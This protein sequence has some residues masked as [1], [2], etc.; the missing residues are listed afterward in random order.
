M[1]IGA[2]PTIPCCDVP[3]SFSPCADSPR[4]SRSIRSLSSGCKAGTT[5]AETREVFALKGD[6]SMNG[7]LGSTAATG[8]PSEGVDSMDDESMAGDSMVAEADPEMLGTKD[9]WDDSTNEG[10]GRDAS[11]LDES[12]RI[13]RPELDFMLERPF[14]GLETILE[15]EECV[16]ARPG[17]S[18]SVRRCLTSRSLTQP[19]PLGM[20]PESRGPQKAPEPLAVEL[21][22]PSLCVSRP[23][24][25]LGTFGD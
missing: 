9:F 6:S 18:C 17:T 8:E 21:M 13:G 24:T 19:G 4:A 23:C 3:K 2:K 5:A 14:F 16:Q 12:G 7:S 20:M 15:E 22:R 10:Q 11:L 1:F 25:H